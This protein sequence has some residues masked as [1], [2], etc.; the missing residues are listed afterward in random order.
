MA[1]AVAQLSFDVDYDRE[2][3]VLY[4]FVRHA[5]ATSTLEERDGLLVDR[6]SYSGEIVGV[7]V[8]DYERRF[9]QLPDL[10]WLTELPLPP[11]LTS[12]LIER[13]PLV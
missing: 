13:Q 9:R 4:L 1:S 10:S 3:D 5:K 11:L 12:F 2:V 6:D 8:L 7:T